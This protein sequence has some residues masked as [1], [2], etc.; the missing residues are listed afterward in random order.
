MKKYKKIDFLCLCNKKMI[1]K[2]C[3]NKTKFYTNDMEPDVIE[4]LED[5]GGNQDT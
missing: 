5:K 2:L 4:K 3:D 1:D